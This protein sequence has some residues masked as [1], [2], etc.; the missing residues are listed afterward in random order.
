MRE[1]GVRKSETNS[2][3]TVIDVDTWKELYEGTLADCYAYIKFIEEGY[4]VVI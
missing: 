4:D 2:L 3:Y 1:Y